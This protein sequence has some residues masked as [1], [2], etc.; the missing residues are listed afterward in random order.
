MAILKGEA[1]MIWQY[2]FVEFLMDNTVGR[3]SRI[4]NVPLKESEPR[5]LQPAYCNQLG[6]EG[7]EMVNY[8]P[9]LT[10]TSGPS[11]VL[12]IFKR[13]QPGGLKLDELKTQLGK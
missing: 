4:N 3:L 7:W 12:I 8:V 6:Q 9:L 13:P 2:L 10:G 11:K 5:P 1:S